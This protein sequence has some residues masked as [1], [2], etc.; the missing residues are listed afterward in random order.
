M[1]CRSFHQ[2]QRHAHA[3]YWHMV[4]VFHTGGPHSHHEYDPMP[5]AWA[6]SSD[7]R[8]EIV[9]AIPSIDQPPHGSVSNTTQ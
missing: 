7:S 9:V 2:F 5:A 4:G 1:F 6:Y 3:S 8:Y